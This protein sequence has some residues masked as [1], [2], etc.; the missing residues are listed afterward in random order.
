MN[1]YLK[2]IAELS[3]EQQELFIMLLKEQGV[4][5]DAS[6]ILPHSRKTN[7][8]PLSSAQQRLWFLDQLE[9]GSPLYN[10]PTALRLTGKLDVVALRRV[11]QE[12]MARHDILRTTFPTENGHEPVQVVADRVDLPLPVVD[13]RH[14]PEPER[15]AEARRLVSDHARRPF[16]LAH[17]PLVRTILLHLADDEFILMLAMHHI[18]ADG[19]SMGVFV[20]ETAA[21]YQAFV[22]GRPSPLPKLAIQ[23]TDFAQWQ[24]RRLG[25]E[26]LAKQIDYW[27]EQ[28]YGAPALLELPTDRPRPHVQTYR[29]RHLPFA[30]SKKLTEQLND[31]S[32]QHD[33]TLFMTLLAALQ[34]LLSRLSGQEDISVGASVANRPRAELESL[35]GFFINTLVMRADLSDDPSFADLLQR[36]RQVAL[37]AYAHQD[38]PFEQVVE[39]VHPLRDMRRTPLFQV[40]FT[41]Q[42]APTEALELP[43]LTLDRVPV[44][45]GTVKFDLTVSVNE[46]PDGRLSGGFGYNTDLFDQDTIERWQHYYRILLAGIVADPDRPVSQLP[47]L[48]KDEQQQTLVAWNDTHTDIPGGGSFVH[49]LFDTQATRT[50]KAP[51]IVIPITNFDSQSEVAVL[52]GELNRRANQLAH[53]LQKLGVGPEKMVGLCVERGMEM[54][55]GLLGILKAGG[56]YLPIDPMY[57]QDRITFMLED[58]DVSVVLTQKRLLARLPEVRDRVT[59]HAVR[60]M[61]R[62]DADW[63]EIAQNPDT[64]PEVQLA[65]DNIAYIIYTS[66]STGTPKGV[67]VTHRALTNY[68]LAAVETFALDSSDRML[69]FA[70]FSFDAAAE[71]IYPTLLAGATLVL[72]NDAML[73]ST[74]AFLQACSTYGVTVLDLPT[75]YWRQI[76]LDMASEALALPDM[77]RLVI[78]GGE[79]AAAETLITWRRQVDDQVRLLNTYGPTEATIVATG[80]EAPATGQMLIL[81]REVPIGRPVPNVR[82]YVLDRHFNPVPIGAPGELCL[83]GVGLAR[84]YLNRPA[85]TARSFVPDPFSSSGR[86]DRL[87][88]TGDLVRYLPDGNIEFIG[89]IDYQVKVRGFRIELGEVETSLRRYP[90]LDD[91]VVV[92][93]EDAPGEKRLVAYFV[94]D[95]A[96]AP[97]V[98]DLREF[99]S[100]EL[101]RY[102]IPS[103][104]IRLDAMPLL[105]SGKVDR[106]SLPLPNDVRP[107]LASEYV[108][109]AKGLE[110]YLVELWQEL[111]DIDRVG[112]H[113]DFFELGGDSLRAAVFINRLQKELNQIIWV[114]A[115]FDAPTVAQLAVYLT[116]NYP[117]LVARRWGVRGADKTPSGGALTRVDQTKIMEMRRAIAG[118]SPSP[119]N[120]QAHLQTIRSKNPPA[121]FI[122]SAPRSGSTLLRVMLAGHPGLFSP[123]ELALLSYHS[124]QSRRAAYAGRDEGWLEGTLR[125]VME[126]KKIDLDEARQLMAGYERQSLPTQQFYRLLQEWIGART[127][128]DKTTTYASSLM[129]LR[130]AEVY[131]ENARYIHLV[132]HPAA[133]VQSYLASRLDQVFGHGY[134]FSPREKAELYWLI[135]NQNI[136]D[137]FAEIPSER[138]HFIHFED[139]VQ[140][141]ERVMR[142][143]CD[144]LGVEF[145]PAVLQPYEGERM[146][147]GVHPESRM[148]G[149]PGF[150]EREDIDAGEAAKWQT[151]P[152]GDVLS[153]ETESL[154]V[155]LGYDIAPS[156]AVRYSAPKPIS[157]DQDL[158]LSFAQQRLWFLDQLDPGNPSY[159]IPLAVRL[160]GE[161]DMAALERTLNE[162]V[163]RHEVLRTTF[164]T[165]AGKATQVIAPEL[166]LTP[167]IIDL[168]HLAEDE[169]ME[170]VGQ[171]VL[172][173]AR[174][175][176]DLGAG[177]LLR[178]VLLRLGEQD[179]AVLLT[180][181]HIISDGWSTGVLIHEIA[182][183][184]RAFSH[185]RSSP[186]PDPSIQ[187]ADYAYWQRQWLQGDVLETQLQYWREQLAGSPPLLEL[188]TDRP[189]PALQTI[190]GDLRAFSLPAELSR[191]IKKLGQSEGA[192]LFMTLM[193]AF[194][195]L[196]HRYSGQDDILV[197]TPIAGRNR[198]QIENLIGFFVN[199]LVLR[200]D[201]S[202][203]PT[204]RQLLQQVRENAT[205]AFAHQDVP[206][207]MLVD[208]LQ[209]DRDMSHSP[210]FQVMFA[211]QNTPTQRLELPGLTLESLAT[212]TLS[213]KFDLTLT[214]REGSEGLT[215][216]LEYNTDLFDASTAE[217]MLLHFQTLL[218][219]M[220]ANPDQP[221]AT[222]SII[223]EREAQQILFDWNDTEADYP[224]N[225]TIPGRFA[226]QTR[227]TPDALAVV[228]HQDQLTFEQLNRRAN[229]LAH[230][231]LSLGVGPDVLVGL[232]IPRSTDL[233]VGVMGIL[234][235]G[236]AYL[237]LDP[238][239]PRDRLAFMLED[240]G[241][242]VVVTHSSSIALL[243]DVGALS[244]ATVSIDTDWPIITQQ[245]DFNP[246]VALYPTNLAYIIYTS[247]STGRPKGVV[248]S[249]RS[250]LN[251]GAALQRT[252]YEPTGSGGR[253][254]SLDAPLAFDASVQQ[255]IMLTYGNTLVII[256]DDLRGDARGLLTYIRDQRIDLFDCVPSQLK[257]LLEAGLLD[258][259]GWT[260]AVALPGGEAI[261]EPVWRKLARAE[262]TDFFNVYG[263][264]EC[265]VDVTT[266]NVRLTPKQPTIGRPLSNVRTY[267]LDRH[268]RPVP[269]GVF[270]ELHL[271]G[272]GVA[273]GYH[274]RP[275]L[276]AERFIPD[277]FSGQAGERL[278]RTGDLVRYLPDGNI[279]FIGRIDHQVKVRGFRIELGE[280]ET[281]LRRHRA[282]QDAVAIVRED[283]PGA[284]RLVAYVV[285]HEGQAMPTVGDLRQ[286]LAHD[287]P[288]YMVPSVFVRLDSLPLTPNRK[289]DRRALPAPDQAERAEL[290]SEFVSPQTTNEK[291][292]AEIWSDILGVERIG[293]HDN[294]FELGGDSIL[295]IQVVARAGT[296]GLRITPQQVFQYPT[297]GGLA[298]AAETGKA[299]QAAQG[300]VTGSLPLTP[301]Q[302]WF[303]DQ[304]FL[305]PH[306]WNQALFLEVKQPLAP[307]LLARVVTELM[308][309]HDAL[310]LRFRLTTA[311]WEQRMVEPGDAIPY[312]VED[313]SA[314]PASQQEE[315]LSKRVAALQSSLDIE[316]G[317]LFRVAYFDLGPKSSH[318]LFIVIHHL[319]ID[320]VSWRILLED[321]QMGYLQAGRGRPISLPPKTT[322][323][324]YWAERLAEY[325]HS[326]SLREEAAYW[327]SLALAAPPQL[328]VDFVGGNNVRESVDRVGVLLTVEETTA[329]LQEAPVIYRTEIN[330]LLLAALARSF[331]YWTGSDR[332]LVDVEGHGREDIFG[333]V[334]ISRT[335]GW[336]TSLYPVA[337]DINGIRGPGDLIKAVKEQLR[338][339]PKRGLGYGLL[340]YLA[341]DAAV[342]E[343][344]KAV[345]N[346]AVS[347]NYL[348]QFD[349]ALP[350]ESPFTLAPEPGGPAHSPRSRRTHLLDISGGVMGGSLHLEWAYSQAIHRRETIVWLADEYIRTLRDLI[351]HCQSPTAGG[352]TPSD[353]RMTDLSQRQLDKLVKKLKK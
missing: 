39:A 141:P 55:V 7:R 9:P 109:P 66:G 254:I 40:L 212:E 245:P 131:F 226:A 128:V 101:P 154:A 162:I 169:K 13:L 157:R 243:P 321:L 351:A 126:I 234:K 277:P 8:F 310:R 193:A 259:S 334:D 352:V 152:A 179:H 103:L 342:V 138:R 23:Y 151:M 204:F 164:P 296:A 127:L 50:P 75:A 186:L 166:V 261:A 262:R 88:R 274:N 235:A 200:T 252:V 69:Q 96:S 284:K 228:Y 306:H 35:I 15:E 16:D 3:P 246:A 338:Q 170:R 318:R 135:N 68:V 270:G 215:G 258:G 299:V 325:A 33:A 232:A 17:G 279:E 83:G 298:A 347:F 117:A 149:D 256:P 174:K 45:T 173:E 94:A 81:S 198:A 288:D 159:N 18:V 86:G 329:L 230:H 218:Q 85:Q 27:R 341:D 255:F 268:L 74:P 309:H 175:A 47:L 314:L 336:F 61:V 199:T 25:A 316:R 78:I 328:P 326:P 142:R 60:R 278:Y 263:P 303:F 129:T 244:R 195:T 143:V 249:H 290:G 305:D 265:T 145:D 340:R 1:D 344:M 248:I 139:L 260:P 42:N 72:R 236:G 122:L 79:R 183:L 10:I 238:T 34:V 331:S 82:A 313:L 345:P 264:T 114:A 343:Q 52:Y 187:Y 315:A 231:L 224:H 65:L 167:P 324:K 6:F 171:S 48:P 194:Q 67:Q 273:R 196:L 53:Y 287:L 57:P 172:E 335:V 202:E 119:E 320:G 221:V 102:S 216:A 155:A 136:Q 327:S 253:R 191:A 100:H 272:P 22:N 209:P 213:A 31:L 158:P 211:M 353:F 137:F 300:L 161:L 133:M 165:I 123:P 181:H 350:A 301:I 148:V 112:I 20:Q 281:V 71:E 241:V 76:A 54:M 285:S 240:A 237:P 125:A 26:E 147:N 14:L 160:I 89:R 266:A 312:S 349:Q 333:D 225:E 283:T 275:G 90:A 118:R 207:E 91:V 63:P 59:Q 80:W 43:D 30:L 41:L 51:A 291:I 105:P 217:R 308:S 93:R 219:G 339:V 311:G 192:T 98:S 177:P 304:D 5:I 176:F 134:P 208:A 12:I 276:T 223:A 292:L 180:M 77:L 203:Q 153:P 182:A 4:D 29:G 140:D 190:D 188:P 106:R 62:L 220:V 229:Q 205:R 73:S 267:V 295:S 251:L 214:M 44:S 144:F 271:G 36:V 37:D 317:P 115:L 64:A 132:R 130:R 121:V 269:V 242:S 247:G 323:F 150:L 113:D 206:F 348:G 11:L 239:Y 280:I 197:G 293:V 84:D 294:F 178:V 49:D 346:A 222:L 92:A 38:V 58:A 146:T 56:A 70:S 250:A 297:V 95:E 116:E 28:L 189:R 111:L 107:D 99:L 307:A 87:Y 319:A 302:Q 322:S 110:T 2:Q 120:E 184:Y 185:N 46:L 124:L 21:L 32:Q 337:L 97:T 330:D 210:L 156:G 104:L 19:W 201:F 282:L 24:Q 163:R 332:L 168:T 286:F 257:M 227:R 233:L 108:A 289:I